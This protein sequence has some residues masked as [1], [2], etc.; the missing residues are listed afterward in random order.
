MGAPKQKWTSEEEAA[1]KAGIVKHGAG[2]WQG[3]LKD[4]EF[5]PIL[6]LRSNVDL[7][8]KWRNMSVT[9]NG[10]GS[11]EKARLALKKNKHSIEHGEDSLA[12]N[13]VIQ[14]DE[15]IIDTKPLGV[16]G[17]MQQ[18]DGLKKSM[19]RE[20]KAHIW[21][22]AG[23]ERFR[24]VTSAYYRGT[25]GALI[26]YDIARRTTFNSV[27]RWLELNSKLDSLILEAIT[28]LKEPIKDD[29]A[30]YIEDQYNA[31][32][33]FNKV[34][35]AKLK[36]MTAS[37]KLIKVDQVTAL[38]S[39]LFCPLTF[40]EKME[41]RNYRIGPDAAFSEKR[42]S[43]ATVL[44]RRQREF[45]RGE[46]GNFKILTNSQ[47]DVEVSKMT[48]RA[49]L[50]EAAVAAARAIAEAEA[51]IA[52]AEDATREAEAAE[53]DSEAAQAFAEAAMSYLRSINTSPNHLVNTKS[54]ASS[55]YTFV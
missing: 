6:C 26:V 44:E 55:F 51:A 5:S 2:K 11:R 30:I 53:A 45:P 37:G 7:K 38:S 47:I 8:D 12:I 9:A 15:E 23:Q 52:E 40:P 17:G 1:L 49:A 41:Q 46:S 32:P 24:A 35:S 31:P 48:N 28:N 36:V 33:N 18:I 10:W 29:I 25:V 27:S 54:A 50:E 20:I 19:K 21:N 14:S 39:N 43:T 42:R 34:L 22:T 4:P 3:I 13:N 16:S